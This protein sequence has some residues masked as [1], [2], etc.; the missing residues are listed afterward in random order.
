MAKVELP[1][2]RGIGA[3][4]KGRADR[5]SGPF[6]LAPVSYLARTFQL[7]LAGDGSVLP[8][9]S[10]AFTA[11]VWL[12][13]ARLLYVLLVAVPL[14]SQIPPSSLVWKVALDGSVEEKVNV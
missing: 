2:L 7:R 11:N 1:A 13:L 5:G 10:V 3:K 9:A 6:P 12:P 14:D 8:A 4:K